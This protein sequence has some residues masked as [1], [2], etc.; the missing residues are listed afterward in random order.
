MVITNFFLVW[1]LAVSVGMIFALG[2]A[3]IPEIEKLRS[4]AMRPVFFIS[5]IFFSLQDLPKAHWKWFDWNPLLHAVELTRYAAYP[6][7]GT[8][9]V[10]QMYLSLCVLITLLLSLSLYQI[11]WKQAISR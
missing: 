3:F 6:T 7:Y 8:A 4:L 2:R 9:G 10:S 1:V 11:L 5:G